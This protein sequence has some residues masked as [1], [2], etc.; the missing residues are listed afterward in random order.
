VVNGERKIERGVKKG[1][2]GWGGGGGGGGG[3]EMAQ[4]GWGGGGGVGGGGGGGGGGGEGGGWGRGDLSTNLV[5]QKNM[6]YT[7]K[8]RIL[9][10]LSRG[11]PIS[12]LRG[13]KKRG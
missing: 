10:W 8:N 2:G 12:S 3:G 1:A 4:G 7:T 5:L 6:E 9:T 13:K 11:I